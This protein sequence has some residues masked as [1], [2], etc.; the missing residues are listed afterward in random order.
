MSRSCQ[1]RST[2]VAS[3]VIGPSTLS[4]P[5]C[6]DC[7][8]CNIFWPFLFENGDFPYVFDLSSNLPMRK[9]TVTENTAFQNRPPVWRFD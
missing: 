3:I 8:L 4:G 5:G 6:C 7:F 2:R 1:Y 9:A